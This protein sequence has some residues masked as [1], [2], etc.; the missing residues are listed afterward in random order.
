MVLSSAKER[1]VV[2]YTVRSGSPVRLRD[3][4]EFSWFYP[5]GFERKTVWE[6][7]EHYLVQGENEAYRFR[8]QI[9]ASRDQSN[10]ASKLLEVQ[11]EYLDNV[12]LAPGLYL[13]ARGFRFRDHEP[14][15]SRNYAMSELSNLALDLEV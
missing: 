12:P 6:S 8:R 2:P 9:T 1:P 15:W 11:R 10:L 4:L 3:W 14:E 13:G 7:G 5:E